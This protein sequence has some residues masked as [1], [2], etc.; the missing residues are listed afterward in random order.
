MKEILLD[1]QIIIWAE[2]E[3][4][5]ISKTAQDLLL[6]PDIIKYISHVSIWEISLK[7][8]IGKLNFNLSWDQYIQLQ[9]LEVIKIELEHILKIKQL[10]LFHRD[11]FDRILIAQSIIEDIPLITSDKQIHQYDFN[12]IS[13]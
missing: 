4:Q 2:C 10:P 8:S 11:P 1:T 13:A 6:D 12:F 5:R 7:Q 3:P 9:S